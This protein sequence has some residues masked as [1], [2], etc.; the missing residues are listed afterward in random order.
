M[1]VSRRSL[2]IEPF[3]IRIAFKK[4]IDSGVRLD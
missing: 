2:G 4:I 3:A 1:D